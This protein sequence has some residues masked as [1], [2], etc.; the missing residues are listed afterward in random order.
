MTGQSSH[1][2]SEKH[3][4]IAG[5][6]IA[7]LTTAL[8][9]A[10]KGFKVTLCERAGVFSE[11]GAGLQLS[12][13]VTRLLKR[14]GV[15]DPLLSRATV[16]KAV[17]L[18]SAK[19]G[20][21]LLN[22]STT[23]LPQSDGAP[24][25]AVHRADLQAVLVAKVLENS[26]I[27]IKTGLAF[28]S[29]SDLNGK[30]A[31]TFL[32]G[33]EPQVI[34]ADVLI[35]ADGVWSRVR[36]AIPGHSDTRHSGYTAWRATVLVSDA[37]PA[38]FRNLCIKQTVGAFLSPGAHLVVY[39]LRQGSTL[40]LVL[41]TPG[42]DSTHGWDN[43]V[44]LAVLAQTLEQFEPSMRDCLA[45]ITN[46][47]SWPL[48]GCPPE[49]AWT[50]GRIALA[51][52]AAHAMTPFA[53]QGACMAIEDAIVLADCLARDGNVPAALAAYETMRKPRVTKVIARGKFNRFAYHVSGP[54]AFARNAV[55]ALRG[56]KL[57]AEL[58]WLYRFDAGSV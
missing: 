23:E 41:V 14:L 46:W 19:S 24:F 15:L 29:A 3:A 8:T 4:V 44:D 37:L 26:D 38:A 32:K 22:L 11:V 1:P 35:G 12:P 30:I 7:G 25:L 50:F 28:Q 10:D 18:L 17:A 42:T 58:D 51:G 43:S 9:L 40:N 31:A 49:G 16:T 34:Q 47:R 36:S 48:H 33:D 21:L 56:Q 55:F 39:P 13:N 5:A 52:D 27:V 57:M 2:E 45:S 6:G 54:A 53:A 20:E